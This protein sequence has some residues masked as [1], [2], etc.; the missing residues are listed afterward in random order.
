MLDVQA[1][2]SHLRFSQIQMPRKLELQLQLTY[3]KTQR[4]VINVFRLEPVFSPNKLN[5]KT[6]TYIN[7]S[8]GY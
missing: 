6:T 7:I 2:V 1:W 4:L 8:A 5:K 3:K